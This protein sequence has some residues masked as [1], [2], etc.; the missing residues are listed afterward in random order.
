MIRVVLFGIELAALAIIG[1][2]VLVPAM[3]LA[4]AAEAHIR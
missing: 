4:L 1:A 2:T 3:V